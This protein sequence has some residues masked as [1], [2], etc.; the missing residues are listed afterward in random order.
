V[1]ES[2]QGP[3]H[4]KGTIVDLDVLRRIFDIGINLVPLPVI[5]F[6]LIGV[7]SDISV[8][9]ST[10]VR[11]PNAEIN[12]EF[13]GWIHE[14]FRH[15]MTPELFETSIGQFNL[16]VNGQ[17]AEFAESFGSFFFKDAPARIF[18]GHESAYQEYVYAYFS[19]AAHALK[20]RPKWTFKMEVGAGLGRADIVFYKEEGVVVEVKRFSHDKKEGYRDQERIQLSGGTKEALSQCDTRHYRLTMP[21]HVNT[22]YEYGLAFVGPYCAV[23]ARV[24]KKVN[25]TWVTNLVYTAEEDE[26]RRQRT[27]CTG[28]SVGQ[29]ITAPP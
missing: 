23:E 19:S 11:I 20:I 16:L 18:G 9:A 4:D 27:Y 7:Q 29:R 1:A 2:P 6:M 24:L 5:L 25:G 12:S 14:D 21:E 3:K 28:V 10:L 22:V 13:R 17:F 8:G 15:R 26:K